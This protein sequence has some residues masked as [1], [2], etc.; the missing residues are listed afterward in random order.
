MEISAQDLI[1][2]FQEQFPKEFT[3]CYQALQIA[4]MK[5][6]MEGGHEHTHEEDE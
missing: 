6:E 2:A 4:A 1:R 3:I 5:A